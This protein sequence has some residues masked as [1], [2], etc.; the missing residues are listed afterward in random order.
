MIFS[1]HIHV[2]ALRKFKVK[3][4]LR[5][6]L[7]AVLIFYS[8]ILLNLTKFIK[9]INICKLSTSFIKSSIE[10]S[11]QN[12]YNMYIIFILCQKYYYIFI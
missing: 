10:Y 6:I 8:Q 9:K 2:H 3:T 5:F 12:K 1:T 11:T 7:Y 4:F